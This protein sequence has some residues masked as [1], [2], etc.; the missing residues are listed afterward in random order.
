MNTAGLKSR[1]PVFMDSGFRRNDGW[2]LDLA[3][4]NLKARTLDGSE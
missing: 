4:A 3:G 1:A 2:G